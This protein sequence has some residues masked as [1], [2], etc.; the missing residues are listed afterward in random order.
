M[1]HC[2]K[3]VRRAA[4]II[5]IAVSVLLPTSGVFAYSSNDYSDATTQ[6]YEA[7]LERL[8]REQTELENTLAEIR[9]NQSNASEYGELLTK[10]LQSTSDKIEVAT[11]YIEVLEQGISDKKAEIAHEEENISRTYSSILQRMRITYEQDDESLLEILLN[12]DGITDLLSRVERL[13]SLL[14]YDNRLKSNYEAAKQ[15]LEKAKADLDSKLETQIALEA[16]LAEDIAELEVL[17]KENDSYI[18]TLENNEKYAYE[19]HVR[20][21]KEKELLA[22]ELDEYI[23]EQ[24]RKSEAE[25]VGGQFGWPLNGATNY[26][27]TCR[28]GWRTYQI[29][30]YWTTDYHNGIDL[31]CYTGTEVYASNAGT[32]IIATYH[33][34]YGYYVLI[35]HGGGYSTLYAHNSKLLV[36][37]GQ[38][39]ERGEVIS[40]SGSTGYSS[41]PHLHFEIRV[42]N[43]RVDPLSGNLLSTPRN[44]Q[45]I[46]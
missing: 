37:P 9:N 21:E 42:N 10:Q 28:H 11:E 24:L 16:E 20:R 27:V 40:L 26:V 4:V 15:Y 45:I 36:T 35:D 6:A 5:V 32:V 33:A 2:F 39:V 1:K 19:E 23:A 46:E 17:I 18:Q 13:S 41:G 34:S 29:Y 25:Y 8:R 30:G 3:R 12:S 44:M 7:E 14:D 31:R 43:E 38:R 22:K